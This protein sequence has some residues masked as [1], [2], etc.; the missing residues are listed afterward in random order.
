MARTSLIKFSPAVVFLGAGA[1]APLDK[2]TMAGFMPHLIR[3]LQTEFANVDGVKGLLFHIGHDLEDLLEH[4]ASMASMPYVK[5]FVMEK[6]D[7]LNESS[8]PPLPSN[9]DPDGAMSANGPRMAGSVASRLRAGAQSCH[10]A[11]PLG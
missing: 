7:G 10:S 3:R 2:P 6:T 11:V 1:S 9:I 8:L 4:L 5:A